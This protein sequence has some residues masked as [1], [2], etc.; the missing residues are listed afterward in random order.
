MACS[1]VNGTGLRA[2]QRSKMRSATRKLAEF[3]RHGAH[4]AAG[5]NMHRKARDVRLPAP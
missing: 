5:G 2:A 1:S 3:M 4:V